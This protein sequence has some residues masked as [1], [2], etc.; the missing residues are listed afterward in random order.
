VNRTISENTTKSNTLPTD[1]SEAIPVDIE[2]LKAPL[3]T[4]VTDVYHQTPTPLNPQGLPDP[5]EFDTPIT[6][7]SYFTSVLDPQVSEVSS[8]FRGVSLGEPLTG[9]LRRMFQR[10]ESSLSQALAF[11]ASSG[12]AFATDRVEFGA[13][14]DGHLRKLSGGSGR[15]SK[16]LSGGSGGKHKRSIALGLR[17]VHSTGTIASSIHLDAVVASQGM[18]MGPSK[19]VSMNAVDAWRRS[20]DGNAPAATVYTQPFTEGD[21]AFVCEDMT[22]SPTSTISAVPWRGSL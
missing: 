8:I 9:R 22:L 15:S 7:S 16:K 12:L 6:K 21:D 19:H 18:V 10:R 1:F 5:E 13:K 2:E 20:I 14:I 11:S 4:A 17:P 3:P